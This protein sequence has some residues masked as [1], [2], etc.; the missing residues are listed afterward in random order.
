MNVFD[1]IDGFCKRADT[2]IKQKTRKEKVQLYTAGLKAKVSQSD[3]ALYNLDLLS[4][5]SDHVTTSTDA[6]APDIYSQVAFFCDSFCVAV[7]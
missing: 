6:A 7:H 4:S 5:K 1:E 3:F 2:S